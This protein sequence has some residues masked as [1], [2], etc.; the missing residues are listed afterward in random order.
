MQFTNNYN[1]PEGIKNAL[2]NDNYVKEGDFSI[3]EL[4]KPPQIRILEKRRDKEVTADVSDRLWMLLGSAVHYVLE[5]GEAE[6]HITEERLFLETQGVKVSGKVDLYSW[7][8]KKVIDYKVT[9]VW[10]FLL[11]DK[12]EWEQQLNM[13]ALLYHKA[14]FKV[15][16][17]EI[18]AIL[19]DWMQSKVNGSDYPSIPFM[20]VV[21]P[22]WDFNKTEDFLS[23][24]VKLHVDSESL[25][26]SEL[27]PCTPEEQ[28]SKQT[29]YALM[30]KGRKTAV[31]V[32][33]NLAYAEE[34]FK[35]AKE[36]KKGIFYIEERPGGKTRCE[37]YCNVKNFCH[38]Y[39]RESGS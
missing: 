36:T 2:V 35:T 11:G 29:K 12:K 21:I 31:R 28:W 16:G 30:K 19:R 27:P 1:I 34:A 24:R 26:D 23:K 9:S 38:Q 3:T 15:E 5:Q 39:K 37:R 32:F 6:E 14:G 25:S 10:S 17:L 4:I 18:H 8:E 22:L 33:D 13:Y 20:T 7:N